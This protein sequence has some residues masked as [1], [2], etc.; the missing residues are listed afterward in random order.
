MKIETKIFILLSA[1][2]LIAFIIGAYNPFTTVWSTTGLAILTIAIAHLFSRT[3]T[4][5]L[6]GLIEW[7]NELSQQNYEKSSHSDC[8]TALAMLTLERQDEIGELARALQKRE[9][10]LEQSIED[11]RKAIAIKERMESEL[12][13]GREIQMDMLILGASAFSKHKDL[14]IY[15]TLKPAREVGGDFYDF[16]FRRENLSYLFEENRFCFCIGDASGKGVPAALFMAVIK[17][18]LKSQAYIDLSPAK[19]LTHVNDVISAENP[20]C[21]FVT[22]FFGVLN[23]A[24]GELVYTNA[25]H[26]PPY[27]RRQNGLVEPLNQRHGTALGVLEGLVYKEDKTTLENGDILITYTDGVTEA[28]DQDQTLFSDQR[29]LDLLKSNQYSS[30]EEVIKL[31]LAAIE[32]FQGEVEQSDDLT[33]LALQFLREP[34]SKEAAAELAINNDALSSL[35]EQWR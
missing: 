26:N 4:K 18:L 17:T 21:M 32:A 1:T 24:D 14:G 22:L 15:A 20:S 33:M 3:I 11:L 28:M 16:Y 25:G 7:T 31:T 30:A 2:A 13:I 29:F 19:I 5:P 27:I 9:A 8:S 34:V 10:E 35:R 12:Q 6:Q 23:L